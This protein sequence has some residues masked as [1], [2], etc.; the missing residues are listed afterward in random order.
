MKRTFLVLTH[1]FMLTWILLIATT[2]HAATLEVGT[3]KPYAAIQSA[4]NDAVNDDTILV[5]DGTYVENINFSGKAIS[6]KSVN[7]ADSTT[8][9]GNASGSVVNFVSGEGSGSVLDGFTIRNGNGGGGIAC[10][11]SSPAITNCTISGNTASGGGG[12]YCDRSSPTITNCTISGN[13]ASNYGGGIA[14]VVSSSPAITNCTIS[15][16]SVSASEYGGGGI[17]C[18]VSSSPV[19]TNCTISGNTAS[20]GGGIYCRYSSSPTITNCTIIG[21]TAG[22]FGGGIYCSDT[23]SPTI[24]NC[25]ISANTATEGGGGIY[26]YSS[27][28]A[29][30][31]CTITGNT[32]DY[33]GGISSHFASP[34]ITNCTITGNTADVLGGGIYCFYSSSPTVKNTILWGNTTWEI[35]GLSSTITITYSDID[36]DGIAG[37]NGNIRQDPL[38]VDPANG[39]F[40]L[41][42]NSPCIDAATSDNAPT[43]DMEGNPRYDD[44]S[45]PNTGGGTYPYYDIGAF[46]YQLSNVVIDGCDSG[47]KNLML[48]NGSTMSDMINTCANGAKNHGAFVSCVAKLTNTWEKMELITEEQKEA[49]QSCAAKASIP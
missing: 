49:I 1:F 45:M 36:E 37:T 14:C 34:T 10:V 15:G 43:T 25:T 38:F 31:N 11:L 39:N 17:F 5:Y 40:H 27:S 8:I 22:V 3:G 42:P 41:Q 6:V 33:G 13:S 12:I 21:N 48:E 30:T 2:I 26:C 29:I 46:E 44:P 18:V 23:S 35:V 7:G 47:V 4:I 24:T 28:P 20:D 32:A 19:I 16:N 9:D